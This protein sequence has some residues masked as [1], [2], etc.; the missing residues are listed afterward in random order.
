MACDRAIATCVACGRAIATCVACDRPIATCVMC[1]SLFQKLFKKKIQWLQQKVKFK[2]FAE[3][4][5]KV[6]V[7]YTNWLIDIY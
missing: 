3:V 5:I 1:D 4:R 2:D 6:P 7:Y